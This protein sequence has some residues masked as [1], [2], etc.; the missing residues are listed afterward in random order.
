VAL[1]DE[2]RADLRIIHK[3]F[4]Q[5]VS[6]LV[7][8]LDIW[9]FV[10]GCIMAV[11]GNEV[12]VLTPSDLSCGSIDDST[13]TCNAGAIFLL[14]YQTCSFGSTYWRYWVDGRSE[15]LLDDSMNM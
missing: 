10:I 4:H 3:M 13:I 14:L 8:F 12:T 1:E 5:K 15:M 6:L 2:P 11:V 9:M 7:K